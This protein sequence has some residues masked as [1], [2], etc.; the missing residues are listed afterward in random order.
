MES[1]PTVNAAK[2]KEKRLDDSDEKLKSMLLK[3]GIIEDLVDDDEA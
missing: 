1:I 3:N 2:H